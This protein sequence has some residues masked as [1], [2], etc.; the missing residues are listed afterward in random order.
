MEGPEGVTEWMLKVFQHSTWYICVFLIVLRIPQ[1]HQEWLY[2]A[3][4]VMVVFMR[5]VCL[6]VHCIQLSLD[7]IMSLPGTTLW[8]PMQPFF[9]VDPAGF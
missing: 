4:E 3:A 1:F 6:K 8:L 7:I 9:T 5:Y 2:Y